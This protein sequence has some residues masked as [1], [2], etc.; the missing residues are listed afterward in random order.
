MAA[1]VWPCEGLW[2]ALEAASPPR[3]RKRPSW[4][5]SDRV[6]RPQA[7]IE[8]A[9]SERWRPEKRHQAPGDES[10]RSSRTSPCAWCALDF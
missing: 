10:A 1:P 8:R 5:R 7:A 4:W 9:P 6:K 2:T 3:T